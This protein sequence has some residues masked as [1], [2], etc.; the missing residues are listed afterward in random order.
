MQRQWK[1][2]ELPDPQIEIQDIQNKNQD[3]I[4]Y[5]EITFD[6]FSNKIMAYLL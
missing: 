1:A 2:D 3:Y 5:C 4:V 6:H